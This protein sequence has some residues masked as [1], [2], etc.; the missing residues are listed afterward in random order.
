MDNSKLLVK[1]IRKN[2]L[3]EVQK[4]LML[5]SQAIFRRDCA[6]RSLLKVTANLGHTEIIKELKT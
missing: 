6:N 4:L 5:E 3:M 1:A 2:D